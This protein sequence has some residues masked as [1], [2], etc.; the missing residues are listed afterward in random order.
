MKKLAGITALIT[1][2]GFGCAGLERLEKRV[3]RRQGGVRDCT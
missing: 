2:L 1:V 3:G